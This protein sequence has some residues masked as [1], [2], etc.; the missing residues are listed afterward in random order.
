MDLENLKNKFGKNI[1]FHGGLDSQ[2][3]LPFAKPED[4]TTEVKKIKK[5]FMG[6]GGIIL[7]PSHYLTADIPIKNILAIY[8]D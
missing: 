5:M 2:K 3:F 1:C 6:E 7:G 8:K 4:I